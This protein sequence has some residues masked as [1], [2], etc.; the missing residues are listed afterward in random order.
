MGPVRFYPFTPFTPFSES[1]IYC[2]YYTLVISNSHQTSIFQFT[3]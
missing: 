1:R 3:F 2:N